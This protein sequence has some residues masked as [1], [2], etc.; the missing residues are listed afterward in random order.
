MIGLQFSFSV[1]AGSGIGWYGY[2]AYT[3]IDAWGREMDK[4]DQ[5]FREAEAQETPRPCVQLTHLPESTTAIASTTL[6]TVRSS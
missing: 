5:I 2:K 1:L 3:R 6:G 4:L